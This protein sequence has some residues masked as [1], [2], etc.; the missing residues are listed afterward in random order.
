VFFGVSIVE[1]AAGVED[2]ESVNT[3]AV[4]AHTLG[5]LFKYFPEI[6]LL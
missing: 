1:A 4:A 5:G 3:T 6:C 2:K